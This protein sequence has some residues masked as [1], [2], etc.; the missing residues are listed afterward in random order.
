MISGSRK[1]G[2]A[3]AKENFARATL[4]GHGHKIATLTDP[5]MS[6][7][8]LFG[9]RKDWRYRKSKSIH[10]FVVTNT[11]TSWYFQPLTK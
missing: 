2:N 4:F 6:S 10:N 3:M 11:D 5:I 8:L 7:E 1:I 9:Y